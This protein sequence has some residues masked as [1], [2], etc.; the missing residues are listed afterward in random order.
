MTIVRQSVFAGV[1]ILGF[2]ALAG[3]QSSGPSSPGA[4]PTGV[5]GD[6]MSSDGVAT[7]RFSGGSFSTTA[8]DTGKVL[9]QGTY[10]VAGASV[11]ING[12]SVI[13]QSPIAF[14]CLMASPKQL[15]C[16]SSAGQNFTLI[17]RA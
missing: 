1:V 2:A 9:A 17:R 10:T 12:T 7:S 15:N 3:C 13:R 8:N 11:S 14:N 16:T 4:A 6:W 5:E